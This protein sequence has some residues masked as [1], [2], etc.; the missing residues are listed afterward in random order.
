MPTGSPFLERSTALLARI[1]SE[2]HFH[3]ALM[4][5]ETQDDNGHATDDAMEA[6]DLAYKKYI[7]PG[8]PGR[9]AYLT[10]QGRPVIFVFPE[11]RPHGLEPGAPAS[12]SLG[13]AA[14]PD[15]S[16]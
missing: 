6:M 2:Q 10:Y 12:E 8:A 11:A 1:A 16:G 9:S 15:L 3:I 14:D 5:D 4:Y 13:I 7:G